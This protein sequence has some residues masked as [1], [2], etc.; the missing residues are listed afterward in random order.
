[1]SDL[2]DPPAPPLPQ[3]PPQAG[4]QVPHQAL[5]QALPQATPQVP[6]QAGPQAP[7]QAAPQ[8][9]QQ[10]AP[11][12][13]Q[14]AGPQAP[15]Q[16]YPQG[17]PPVGFSAPTTVWAVPPHLLTPPGRPRPWLRT[18]L[19][20]SAAAGV[21]LVVGAITAA[22]MLVPARTDLP[23]LKTPSD[24]RYSFPPLKLPA[25]PPGA[26]GPNEQNTTNGEQTHAADLRKLLLPAPVGAKPDLSYPGTTGWYSPTAYA[27]KF[28]DTSN[29]LAEFADS[30]LRHIAATAWTGP[31]GT[32]TE[33]Y[34]LAYRSD[35]T[36]SSTFSYDSSDSHLL[37]APYISVDGEI[38]FPGI[39]SSAVTAESQPPAG[40]GLSADVAFV[41][42]ADV[43]AVV[44]M[45]NPHRV[46]PV[47]FT[48][49]VTLQNELL[50]G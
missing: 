50:Q 46:N 22:C 31:D 21:F 6:P 9:P 38:D 25:L 12:L 35:A 26:D 33:I 37:A 36:V 8:A 49:V 13:P 7:P 23:G 14:Q 5:P 45:S 42:C 1:M 4:P 3:A 27:A 29:L 30:G 17:P 18:A 41:D 40:G 15:P 28:D 34:L 44:V 11:Q 24:Q 10:A 32:R 47:T 20:W 48:Q 39:D 19:R 16:P 2:T 43:E